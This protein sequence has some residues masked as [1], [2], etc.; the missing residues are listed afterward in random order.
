MASDFDTEWNNLLNQQ[1]ILI[2]ELDQ[3]SK[4]YYGKTAIFDTD[5]KL[6]TLEYFDRRMTIFEQLEKIGSEQLKLA[7]LAK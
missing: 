4:E 5:T 7:Q 6:V 3:L 1:S 2:A